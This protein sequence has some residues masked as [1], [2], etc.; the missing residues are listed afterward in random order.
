MI[1]IMNSID[2]QGWKLP[3]TRAPRPYNFSSEPHRFQRLGPEGPK[4]FA[5]II[6]CI[7]IPGSINLARVPLMGPGGPQ[8]NLVKF[9][10]WTNGCQLFRKQ[11][12]ARLQLLTVAGAFSTNILDIPRPPP[13]WCMFINIIYVIMMLV[14]ESYYSIMILN[15]PI[16]LNVLQTSTLEVLYEFQQ[17]DEVVFNF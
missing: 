12:G 14:L 2:T 5:H 8:A 16:P 17:T 11:E 7:D 10:P 3:V 6:F 4:I 1:N 15:C 9:H 13:I